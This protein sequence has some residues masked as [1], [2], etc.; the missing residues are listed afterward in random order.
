LLREWFS[1]SII[2]LKVHKIR[3]AKDKIV[4]KDDIETKKRNGTYNQY[5]ISYS[6]FKIVAPQDK[7][8]LKM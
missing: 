4:E 1:L 3:R 7:W 5:Q 8:L 2:N 6:G